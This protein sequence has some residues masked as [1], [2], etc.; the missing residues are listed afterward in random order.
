[1]LTKTDIEQVRAGGMSAAIAPT[2]D[3]L[4]AVY[5]QSSA[6]SEKRQLA[7]EIIAVW[8]AKAA[9]EVREAL[10][11][12]LAHCPFLPRELALEMARDLESVAVPML[13][14]SESLN[15]DDLGGFAR[16]PDPA[17]Q[18]AV[19]RRR[20]VP[21]TVAEALVANGDEGVVAALVT[22][23]GARL[24][25][26]LMHRI[27]DGFIASEAIHEGLA[28]RSDLPVSI[29][30]RLVTMV[31]DHL[32]AHLVERFAMPPELLE[33]L[34]VLSREAATSALLPNRANIET[35]HRFVTHLNEIGRLTPTFL[36]RALC[37][38]KV[39]VFVAGIAC[40]TRMQ[41]AHVET[42]LRAGHPEQQADLFG[43]AGV[44]ELLVPALRAGVEVLVNGREAGE[45]AKVSEAQISDL[46][47]RIVQ[48]YDFIDPLDLDTVLIRLFQ[49][50]QDGAPRQSPAHERA[51]RAGGG[52]APAGRPPV[53]RG[54]RRP[55]TRPR[56]PA[57]SKPCG[58][59]TGEGNALIVGPRAK[60]KCDRG[61]RH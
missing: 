40:R 13:Q 7:E 45:E 16:T 15:D 28:G 22:N 49:A 6:D 11:R 56:K 33:G 48:Q 60:P 61:P 51:R 2:A 17:R 35:A 32:R 52:P 5:R 8:V 18:T 44:P 47:N 42:I 9:A 3:R 14:F 10:S 23:V 36:L 41:P 50:I 53:A 43:R 21:Y 54:E 25:E 59:T 27:V 1:M 34:G 31:S 26:R 12:Q 20:E 38:G 39:S 55:A 46:I 19:A 24:S 29:G 37:D 58:M 4:A 30:E 57:T